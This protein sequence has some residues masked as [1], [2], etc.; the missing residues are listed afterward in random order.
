MAPVRLIF[1][2]LVLVALLTDANA[3]KPKAYN[4]P[5]TD[6][7]Q[8]IIW[9]ATCDGPN[10]T[11]LAF[12]GQDQKSDD[13]VGHT[14]TKVDGEWKPIGD[15]LRKN[16]PFQKDHELC[17]ALAR[18][19][20]EATAHLRRLHFRGLPVEKEIEV[21]R[22]EQYPQFK[23]VLREN[24][25]ITSGDFRKF[26]FGPDGYEK[27]QALA[28][29]RN[30]KSCEKNLA[31]AVVLLLTDGS[32]ARV[33]SM[34]ATGLRH[35]EEAADLLGAEPPARALSSIVYDE[36]TKLYVLSCGDHLDYLMNDTWVFD[37]A[38]KKWEQRHPKEAPPP[39]ANHTLKAA[40]GKV[41][42]SGGYTHSAGFRQAN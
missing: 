26:E 14:R 5:A 42:L 35:A 23:D 22:A 17:P 21:F 29:T 9:G 25:K 27:R 10:G 33:F 34:L 2:C 16:N 6:L 1:T 30:L 28:A 4:L 3:Q 13:G 40:D 39:R 32:N 38:K 31:D 18:Q 37:P 19:V 36:K 15:D 24:L 7:K 8:Q 41:T 12:G 11:G 20:S